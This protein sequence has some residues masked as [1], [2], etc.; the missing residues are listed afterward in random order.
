MTNILDLVQYDVILSSSHTMAS[1]RSFWKIGIIVV[2]VL[3]V[4]W[5]FTTYNGLVTQE[6]NVDTSWRQVETQY[7]RR[8]DLIPNIVST[9]KGAA[10]FEQETL[11]Q[12]TE[13]R[14]NWLNAGQTAD[15]EGEVAAAQQ[16]DSALSRLLVSVEA[17]PQLQ[18]TQAY[19]DLMI[20]LEGTENRISTA[21]RDYN[22]VVRDYNLLVKRFPGNILAGMFGYEAE[23]GFE[24]TPGA[25]NA[26][27][28]D[29]E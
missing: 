21:R 9:V 15:R 23:P 2:L 18:A 10:N 11:T 12:V 20:E 17:Y 13:A 4:V 14:T 25:E 5:V 7:Q 3:L 28:V 26:P 16:M 22:E 19:R 8:F 24:S 27:T 29:F 1:T 6:E